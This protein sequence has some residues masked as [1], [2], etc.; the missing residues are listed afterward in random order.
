LETAFISLF[1]FY[2]ASQIENSALVVVLQSGVFTGTILAHIRQSRRIP[3]QTLIDPEG[4]TANDNET[5]PLTDSSLNST[6]S[7]SSVTNRI[8][9]FRLTRNMTRFWNIFALLLQWSTLAVL[10][11]VMYRF[12]TSP[13]KVAGVVPLVIT[14]IVLIGL[15][16]LWCPDIQWWFFYRHS[17]S[18]NQP[19]NVRQRES[20]IKVDVIINHR[21]KVGIVTG[22]LRILFT[23]GFMLLIAKV[24]IFGVSVSWKCLWNGL[25]F[26]ANTAFLLEVFLPLGS[27]VLAWISCTTKMQR[28]TFVWPVAVSTVGTVGLLF[29]GCAWPK[30]RRMFEL[31][32]L[33]VLCTDSDVERLIVYVASSFLLISQVI[34]TLVHVLRQKMVPM[35]KE[36]MLFIQPFYSCP[37]QEQFLLLNRRTVPDDAKRKQLFQKQTNAKIYICTTMYKESSHEQLQLLRSLKGV[38]NEA[39][40]M[41]PTRRYEAHIF[42]D[43]GATGK[44]INKFA[45]Q[46]VSLIK[47]EISP[48]PLDWKLFTTPY[49]L[50]L[51]TDLPNAVPFYIHLK[52]ENKVKKKKR[53]SQVMYMSYVI[54]FRERDQNDGSSS[55]EHKLLHAQGKFSVDP[56][57]LFILTTDADV[58]FEYRSVEHLIDL[59]Q[60]DPQVGAVCGRTHPVGS[61]PVAWYQ[62]FDYAIGHWFQKAAEHVLGSVTCVPG[63]FSMFRIEAIKTVLATYR[64]DVEEANEFLKK[65][66]GEDRWLSTI[67]VEA[68]WRLE[69]CAAADNETHCP[70]SFD[71]FFNQR[72]RWIPSTM[73]NLGQLCSH[74]NKISNG[75][76][77]VSRLFILFQA[78]M[79]FSSIINPSTVI[80]IISAGLAVAYDID[81][82]PLVA[83]LLVVSAVYGGICLVFTQKVQLYVAKFLTF[84]FAILMGSVIVGILVQTVRS[85]SDLDRGPSSDSNSTAS[86]SSSASDIPIST[87]YSLGLAA[88]YLAAAALH[89]FEFHCVLQS[90]WYLLCLPSGYLLLIIYAIC[91]LDDQNWGT[92]ESKSEGKDQS[93]WNRFVSVFSKAMRRVFFCCSPG[94]EKKDSE[95]Q[96]DDDSQDTRVQSTLPPDHA[97]SDTGISGERFEDITNFLNNCRITDPNVIDNFK[98]DGYTDTSFLTSMTHEELRTLGV[99]GRGNVDRLLRRIQALPDPRVFLRK[100]VPKSISEFLDDLN[101]PREYVDLFKDEGYSKEEDLVGL[102]KLKREDFQKMGIKKQGHL[103]KL[104]LGIEN[105][106][107]STQEDNRI[108]EAVELVNNIEEFRLEIDELNFWRSAS[109]LWLKP[110][111]SDYQRGKVKNLQSGLKGLRNQ[112]VLLFLVTN[113]LWIVLIE[114]MARHT[115]LRLAETNAIGLIFLAVYGVVIAIQFLTII[116]HRLET[117]IHWLARSPRH[118]VPRTQERQGTPNQELEIFVNNV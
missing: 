83:T 52:D 2:V 86:P 38:A 108:I 106:Q 64:S 1:S 74:G 118:Y 62:V 55:R 21:W 65:D 107:Y 105:L 11:F 44:N 9:C 115:E 69:Y 88:T 40:T 36:E 48:N 103:K 98:R 12:N 117:F 14:P 43:G 94:S 51:K 112:V 59:L 63:C 8:P 70:V 96:T 4:L 73:V 3:Y 90:L 53:W 76:D 37:F 17:S 39:K 26:R 6:T 109:R 25:H 71:E 72:R 75:N 110:Q 47:E 23:T 42:F 35:A 84:L 113:V 18:Y 81:E 7:E 85:F 99:T 45:L 19:A 58:M 91:N 77:S 100:K 30:A 56:Q 114:T 50:Q 68:G 82:V 66:M 79:L 57:N 78:V 111:L 33:H 10:I 22:A 97:T 89:P 54:H 24:D 102:L 32:D 95:V 87:W 29:M 93:P 34:S 5:E 27:Y 28:G 15:S 46:L 67:L 80:L 116:W 41:K 61:G 60:R 20:K 92:R 104:S 49:G 16:V 13:S 101:L 31:L